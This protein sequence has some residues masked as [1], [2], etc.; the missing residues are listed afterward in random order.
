MKA[1]GKSASRR[2]SA[3][4][5]CT[6][7]TKRQRRSRSFRKSWSGRPLSMSSISN[8]LAM[9]RQSPVKTSGR[10]YSAPC[11]GGAS[12]IRDVSSSATG[13][14]RARRS[15]PCAASPRAHR[16]AM[17]RMAKSRHH[18]KE[19]GRPLP[20]S[21]APRRKRP[22]PAPRAKLFSSRS[23]S[24]ASSKNSSSA[25]LSQ[26]EP[27]GVSAGASA[28]GISCEFRFRGHCSVCTTMGSAPPAGMS[29]RNSQEPIPAPNFGS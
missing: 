12:S 27:C 5:K 19:G 16:S 2:F 3:R 1:K 29:R 6:R 14:G 21:P 4:L 18:A 10:R 9:S 22:W 15:F 23:A 20:A 25:R 11:I 7:P 28:E 13:A 8:A 24:P 17:K 26:S